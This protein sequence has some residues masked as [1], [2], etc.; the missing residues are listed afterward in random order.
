MVK[1][2]I[3]SERCA[4][5]LS[6]MQYLAL[7]GGSR[8]AARAAL[9]LFVLDKDG[10]YI[11]KAVLDEDGDIIERDGLKEALLRLTA[12]TP[13][14]SERL[15][16]ELMEAVKTIVDPQRGG[17]LKKPSTTEHGQPPPG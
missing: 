6:I 3:S 12:V 13:K 16:D 14:R 11:V 4:D 2:K 1:F 7:T 5:I 9:P 8:D 15:V 17:D 10:E